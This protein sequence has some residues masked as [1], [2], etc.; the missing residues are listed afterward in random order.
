MKNT[1]QEKY[2]KNSPDP[3]SIEGTELILK[4]MKNCVCK[5]YGN[6]GTGFFCKIFLPEEKRYMPVLITNNHVLSKKEIENNKEINLTL[7]NDS[8][9]KKIKIDKKR[10]KFTSKKLDTTI[11]EIKE[12]EDDIH[13]FLEIDEDIQK[14]KDLLKNIFGRNKTSLYILHYPKAETVKVSYGLSQDIKDNLILHTCCTDFGSSGSPILSLKKFKVLGIHYG[15][16]NFEFNKGTFI[17]SA[18]DEFIKSLNEDLSNLDPF[19]IIKENN[20]EKLKKLYDY[21]KYILTKK[22]KYLHTL[23]HCSV[24]CKNFEITKFLLEKGINYDEPDKN[25]R[26][27]L[28]YSSGEIKKLLSSYGAYAEV[29]SGNSSFEG[30]NIQEKDLNIIDNL[31][32]EFLKNDLVSKKI[33]I[34]K[35]D[36]IIG[37]RFIRK[38]DI[39]NK[40]EY[41]FLSKKNIPVYHGTRFVSMENIMFNGLKIYGE[42]LKGHIPLGANIN[43]KKD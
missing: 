36:K 38:I 30:I 34:K 26:T 13:D 10:K 37:I 11:I 17:K 33:L 3:I 8:K 31:Y 42:P 39:E 7:N 15:F 43:N 41:D 1:I 23:L 27:A 40:E 6:N 5:I 35:N 14:D 24:I 18:I 29:F 4:Q 28:A 20:L 19:Q 22:D 12:V 2:I 25:R 9:S 16:S 21:N 32:D